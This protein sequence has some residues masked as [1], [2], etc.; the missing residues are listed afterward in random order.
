M[1]ELCR[2]EN[3]E[4][5]CEERHDRI[6]TDLPEMTNL[7][8]GKDVFAG[9]LRHSFDAY[10][11]SGESV[12]LGFLRFYYGARIGRYVLYRELG[13]FDA[14]FDDLLHDK[15]LLQ[16]TIG[17]AA[18]TRGVKV[19]R[20]LF[21]RHRRYGRHEVRARP[22]YMSLSAWRKRNPDLDEKRHP[23]HSVLREKFDWDGMADWPNAAYLWRKGLWG[24][25]LFVAGP[26]VFEEQEF[27]NWLAFIEIGRHR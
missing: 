15:E 14:S 10:V 23:F 3:L 9:R 21:Q 18:Y 11:S 4:R 25:E 5:Q 7:L 8:Q 1:N 6:V 24:T 16:L 17:D 27:R 20:D 22:E 13:P 2:E 12:D 26:S 19:P